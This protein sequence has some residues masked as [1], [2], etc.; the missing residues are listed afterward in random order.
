MSILLNSKNTLKF[1]KF[2]SSVRKRILR[3]IPD[4][5]NKFNHPYFKCKYLLFAW[6]VRMAILSLQLIPFRKYE[7]AMAT[8]KSGQV[9]FWQVSDFAHVSWKKLP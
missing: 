1:I 5:Y 6:S 4:G 9:Q 2:F 7:S 8:P 3:S